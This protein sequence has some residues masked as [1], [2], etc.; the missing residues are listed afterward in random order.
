MSH[1]R[2]FG[3]S[4]HTTLLIVGRSPWLEK[5]KHQTASLVSGELVGLELDAAV[6]TEAVGGVGWCFVCAVAA[7]EVGAN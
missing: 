4:T 2:K 3:G 1:G 7:E 5:G 6:A